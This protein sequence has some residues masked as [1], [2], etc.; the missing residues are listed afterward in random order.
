MVLFMGVV[1]AAY[2]L[3]KNVPTGFVPNEDMGYF[4]VVL[5]GP[6]STALAR[7]GKVAAEAEK[8]IK[9]LPGVADVLVIGG[10]NIVAGI[11]D[12]RAATAIVVLKPW[13]ERKTKALSLQGVMK[14]MYRETAA[15]NEFNIM[16]F[17]PP[18]IQGLPHSTTNQIQTRQYWVLQQ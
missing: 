13:D 2:L 3:M 11:Q 16:A 6:E 10:Y 4:F 7:T 1:A 17:N 5:E 12:T 15:I 14:S 8:I 9:G 18:P